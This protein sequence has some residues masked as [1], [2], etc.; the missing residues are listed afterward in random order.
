MCINARIFV[1]MDALDECLS[2]NER[3][4]VMML[5]YAQPLTQIGT[6]VDEQF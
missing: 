2:S 6:L 1:I 3:H 5:D 4:M